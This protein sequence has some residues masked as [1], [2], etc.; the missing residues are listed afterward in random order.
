MKMDNSTRQERILS[1]LEGGVRTWDD[2]R[3]LAGINEEGLGLTLG[4]LLGLR[5]IWSVI[6]TIEKE[7]VRF[8]GLERRT[9]LVP[10]SYHQLRRAADQQSISP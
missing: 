9:G 8:Y 2:L 6:R 4:E 5:K 10:R 3:K 7:D 1:A